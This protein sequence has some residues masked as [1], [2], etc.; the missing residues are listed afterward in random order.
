MEVALS[1][2]IIN[3]LTALVVTITLVLNLRT[4]NDFSYILGEQMHYVLSW[5]VNHSSC[6]KDDGLINLLCLSCVH[7]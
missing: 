1:K 3:S 4:T 2:G 5:L 7:R 6:T